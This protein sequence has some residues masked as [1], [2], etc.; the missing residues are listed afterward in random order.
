MNQGEMTMVSCMSRR[1]FSVRCWCGATTV[2]VASLSY[3]DV[4]ECVAHCDKHGAQQFQVPSN[5][6]LDPFLI[7][8]HMDEQYVLSKCNGR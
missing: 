2:L 5:L 3:N 6:G 1:T 7:M 4:R 8:K